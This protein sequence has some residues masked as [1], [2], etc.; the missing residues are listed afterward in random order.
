M[1]RPHAFPESS[2]TIL[3]ILVKGFQMRTFIAPWACL[4]VLSATVS[5]HDTWVQTAARIVR[6][7]DVVHVDLALGNHGNAHRD[8]KFAGKLASLDGVV[9]DVIG[10]SG[11]RTDLVPEMVDLGFA[12]KEGFWS[13]RFV[14]AEP[15]ER[16][17]DAVQARFGRH[18]PARPKTFLG[19]EAEIDH[20]GHEVGPPAARSTGCTARS[21]R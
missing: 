4:C 21:A 17:G 5:A 18:E 8:F 10:P 3:M 13:G 2:S 11:R 19:R 12:A 15:V 16:V 14:T 7:E 20:L 6:P 9:L 1:R